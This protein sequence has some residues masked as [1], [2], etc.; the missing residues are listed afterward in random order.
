MGQ[1]NKSLIAMTWPS[2]GH[3]PYCCQILH[4]SPYGALHS[5]SKGVAAGVIAK[6][7][8]LETDVSLQRD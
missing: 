1:I 4:K 8:S 5:I 2:E 7:A 3:L 6:D